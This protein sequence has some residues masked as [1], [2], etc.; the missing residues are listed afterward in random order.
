MLK[1]QFEPPAL[2]GRKQSHSVR[3]AVGIRGQPS[4]TGE[5]AITEPA[6]KQGWG[7]GEEQL[8]LS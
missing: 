3:V 1:C 2:P 5:V 8:S 4:G 7:Q 6:A